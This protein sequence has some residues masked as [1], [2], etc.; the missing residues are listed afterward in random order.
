MSEAILLNGALI[1][2]NIREKIT[3][4]LINKEVTLAVI[5]IGSKKESEIYVNM[6]IKV[7]N[8][9]GIKSQVYKFPDDALSAEIYALIDKLNS[10]SSVNAILVQ[11]PLPPNYNANNFIKRININKDVD[12]LNA[13]SI[14]KPC[15]PLGCIELL[16]AYQIPIEGRHVVIVGRGNLVGKPLV[17]LLL[18]EN[19]TVTI[20]HSKTIDIQ[21]IIGQADIL[22]VA[23]GQPEFIR[24][25][26]LKKDVVI[27]D[28]GINTVSDTSKKSGYKIVG[29]VNFDE[30][31]HI[32]SA[33]SPV[34]KGVGPMTI[35]MLIQNTLLLYDNQNTII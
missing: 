8:E 31:K 12:G 13:G 25:S 27:V 7:C 24:G 35:T 20:V 17:N 21:Q 22:V 18:D 28:V 9:V 10:D 3:E 14:C 4:K 34:P 32:A 6:K 23:V 26:W 29:D 5:L 33:I 19:A 30:C 2:Q 1:A 15:T 16:K 11:L